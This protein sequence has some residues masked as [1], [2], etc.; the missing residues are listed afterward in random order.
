MSPLLA[1][2]GHA[3]L[4]FTRPLSE[5]VASTSRMPAYRVHRRVCQQDDFGQPWPLVRWRGPPR[6]TCCE[7]A[8]AAIARSVT[9]LITP[10]GIS[11][12]KSLIL[13]A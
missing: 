10:S 7:G 12:A 6:P 2:S 5:V 4:R 9:P 11:L 3:E 8:P 1:Q 13:Q